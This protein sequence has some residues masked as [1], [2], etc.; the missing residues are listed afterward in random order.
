[1]YF[2]DDQHKLNFKATKLRWSNAQSSPEY[3]AACYILAVPMIF[4][5]VVNDIGHWKSP[6]GWIYEW[7]D[8]YGTQP[9]DDAEKPDFDLSSSMV[10]MGRLALNLWNGYEHFNL[11]N[12]LA[13]IDET[14]YE[15]VKTAINIRMEIS[16]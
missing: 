4:E 16:G 5:K 13:V 2:L 6:V 8:K 14:K 11:M 3:V 9:L 15:I 1:M 10:Q 12:C 7:E